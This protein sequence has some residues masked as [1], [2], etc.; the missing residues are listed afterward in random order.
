LPSLPVYWM[1]EEDSGPQGDKRTKNQ[2]KKKQK[3]KTGEIHK[4][5]AE[6]GKEEDR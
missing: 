5:E 1:L 2:K 6:R 4:G 3:K